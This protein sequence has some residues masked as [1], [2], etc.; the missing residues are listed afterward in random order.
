MIDRLGRDDRR[1]GAGGVGELVVRVLRRNSVAE[2]GRRRILRIGVIGVV[3]QLP[4]EN[5]HV[6]C[7]GWTARDDDLQVLA[8]RLGAWWCPTLYVTEYV[9]E[10]RAKPLYIYADRRGDVSTP[11]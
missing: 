10:G 7:S 1:A 5:L 2:N 6:Q 8:K 9:A 11:A 4:R 3:E